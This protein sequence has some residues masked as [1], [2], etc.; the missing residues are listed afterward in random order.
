MGDDA[1]WRPLADGEDG[2][3]VGGPDGERSTCGESPEDADARGVG[4]EDEGVV[5]EKG[6]GVDL[7][8]V[9]AE[10]VGWLGRGWC[11]RGE[12]LRGGHGW[13]WGDAIHLAL[14]TSWRSARVRFCDYICER[15]WIFGSD[16]SGYR[17]LPGIMNKDK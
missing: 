8:G 3:V 16:A 5:G 4:G 14:H 2:G 7:G 12:G 1:V 13:C 6:D 11:A 10:D 9:A 17:Y 15:I